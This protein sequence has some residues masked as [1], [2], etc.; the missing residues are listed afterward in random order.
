MATANFLMKAGISRAGGFGF[1]LAGL[2]GLLRQP[3]FDGGFLLSGCAALMWFQL[4]STQRL[5]TCYPLFVG[6]TYLLMTLGALYLF[7]EEL[8]AQKLA[9]LGAIVFG[10]ALVA[11]S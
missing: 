9:G 2:L 7:R 1:S 8:S 10:I 5:S 4:L 11:R 6:L 3:A